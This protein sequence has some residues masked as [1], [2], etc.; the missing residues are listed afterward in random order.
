[1]AQ[2]MRTFACVYRT[3]GDYDLEYV[4]RLIE[5]V[6]SNVAYEIEVV[7]LS[8]DPRVIQYCDRH[9]VLDNLPGWWSKLN[10]F[11]HLTSSVYADLD[12]IIRG[13]ITPLFEYDHKFT[14]LTDFYHPKFPASGIMAWNGDY[15]FLHSRWDMS[16]EPEFKK[17]GKW[18]DQGW[19]TEQLGFAPDRIQ[20]KFP[21]LCAS[22]KAGYTLEPIVCFHGKP[23][24][25]QV[26]WS[27]S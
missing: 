4:R 16:K 11:K 5:S 22:Y 13:D 14:M 18:G 25:H 24:P 20:T 1:M 12:T 2:K 8:D 21:G 19:I 27:L 23:R 17:T 10:L 9:I 15:S 3:G 26:N 6:R 7:C